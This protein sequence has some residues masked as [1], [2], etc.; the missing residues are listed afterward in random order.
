MTD[1]EI[2][3]WPMTYRSCFTSGWG[4]RPVAFPETLGPHVPPHPL[5]CELVLS[6]VSLARA[7]PLALSMSAP[8]TGS[9]SYPP[10][11]RQPGPYSLYLV[12]DFGQVL[13]ELMTRN[14][15]VNSCLT[16]KTTY[17]S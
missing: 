4:Q 6:P 5:R 3:R 16:P 9:A 17:C 7:E 1:L 8:L 15:N 11:S 2:P 12:V 13:S 10:A 14:L